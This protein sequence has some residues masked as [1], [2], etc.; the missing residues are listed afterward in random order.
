MS[1]YRRSLVGPVG[2]SSAGCAGA[3]AGDAVSHSATARLSHSKAFLRWN[4][5]FIESLLKITFLFG[6]PGHLNGRA[7]AQKVSLA[8][9]TSLQANPFLSDGNFPRVAS[10]APW[11]SIQLSQPW[12]HLTQNPVFATEKR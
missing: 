3:F 6:T 4:M 5:G 7:A 8:L 10:R 1:P 12:Y 11:P 9:Q 2:A